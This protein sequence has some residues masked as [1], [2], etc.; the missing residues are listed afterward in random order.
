MTPG[1][2]GIHRHHWNFRGQ[3][4]EPEP[5]TPAQVQDSLRAVEQMWEIVDSL[6]AEGQDRQ[7]LER[8]VEM[9]ISGNRQGLSRMF[10]GAGAF[11]GGAR[12]PD[13][14]VERPGERFGSGGGGFG[15]GPMRAFMRMARRRGLSGGFMGGG[16]RGGQ[17]PLADEGDYTVV[18][19][20][21]DREFR[22]RLAV[23]KGPGADAGGGFFQLP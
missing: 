11:G 2:P 4:P 5:K 13:E 3:A 8:S 19:K 12:N 21:G 1:T 16:G 7:M 18:L 10:G 20:V 23:K 22:Q 9:M 17:A 14:F 6:V 15:G